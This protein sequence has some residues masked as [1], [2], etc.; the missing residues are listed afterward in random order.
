VSVVWDWK[1]LDLIC[2]R[3]YH[4]FSRKSGGKFRVFG[5]FQA[6]RWPGAQLGVVLRLAG[7]V[8]D[9]GQN[10]V[11]IVPHPS[12]L[13][14]PPLTTLT[15]PQKT[16]QPVFERF[17]IPEICGLP[18]ARSLS[19]SRTREGFRSKTPMGWC[20]DEAYKL[21]G[22]E[23]AYVKLRSTFLIM[24]VDMNGKEQTW[25]HMGFTVIDS[26]C[27]RARSQGVWK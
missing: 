4:A 26:S 27:E 6:A 24:Y 22:P 16:L 23:L 25:E 19:L 20:W 3:P 12:E 11:S 9:S 15:T 8:A 21:Y 1:C 7:G 18:R 13:R 5:D 10:S 2:F 17:R 14:P